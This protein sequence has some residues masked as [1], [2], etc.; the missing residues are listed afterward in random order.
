MILS[1]ILAGGYGTRLWPLSRQSLPKQ[2]LCFNDELTLLQQAVTRLKGLDSN[3]PIVICNEEHRFIVAEQIRQL[4]VEHGG[5]FLEPV[6][7]NTAAAIAIAAIHALEFES[8]QSYNKKHTEN[9][10]EKA[11]LLLVLA[12]DHVID[13]VEAFQTAVKQAAILAKQDKLVT[14]GIV[15]K[16]PET[17]YGYIKRG[18]QV[19]EEKIG[20]GFEVLGAKVEDNINAFFVERFVEKPDLVTA[21]EYVESGEY[22]WNSGMFMFK[23]SR[24]LE[25]LKQFNPD[26]V[27]ACKKAMKIKNED[28]DFV[29][30]EK[31]A[32][33]DCP[34]DSIDY[35]VMEPLTKT[36]DSQV[37]VIPLDAGWNDIG[38]FKA[39]WEISAQ[40]KNNNAISGDVKT[41]DTNNCLIMSDDKLIASVGVDNLVIINTKDIVLIAHKDKAQEVKSI[42][43]QLKADERPEVT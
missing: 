28:M 40:D 22:Y 5:I 14:F 31:Q 38:G 24:Y 41:V 4:G 12:T 25:V 33:M 21:T 30:V 8:K 17:G 10:N 13:D 9:N 7:R 29:R 15:A 16:S 43:N 2:F 27:T 39:L 18:A 1:V 11:P 37:V 34:S 36:T 6:G 19:R 42:V 32:F 26:I 3:P 20:A 23:A 35:A